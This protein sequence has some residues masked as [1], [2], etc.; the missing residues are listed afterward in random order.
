MNKASKLLSVV[1]AGAALLLAGCPKTPT[2]STPADTLSTTTTTPPS[3]IDNVTPQNLSTVGLENRTDEFDKDGQKRGVFQPI[4]FDFDR[5]DIKASERSKFQDLPKYL[6]DHPDQ[7]LLFEGHCDWRGTAEYNL[8]LGDRRA[9]AAK[10]YLISLGVPA[11]K[12]ETLSK[13]SL[14]A[15]KNGDDATMA[16]ERRDEIVILKPKAPVDLSTSG[17]AAAPVTP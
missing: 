10:K 1:I 5:S 11:D 7:H 3:Q 4:Y 17:P 14:D 15:T 16:K 13:G 6:Q 12:I 2:R 9:S 8:G